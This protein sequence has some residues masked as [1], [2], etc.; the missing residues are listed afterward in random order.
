[1][2]V[3][4]QL[5]LIEKELR[6][7]ATQALD[8]RA[9]IKTARAKITRA[10]DQIGGDRKANLRQIF[11]TVLD[12]WV[13]RSG[14]M[15][16]ARSVGHAVA[17]RYSSEIYILATSVVMVA[18]AYAMGHDAE[19]LQMVKTLYDNLKGAKKSPKPTV[20]TESNKSFSWNL[21][22]TT[23]KH[24]SPD[25]DCGCS[26]EKK[27]VEENASACATGAGSI[28]GAAVPM[29][30]GARSG[31]LR[32]KRVSRLG[33][34]AR[35]LDLRFLPS[36]CVAWLMDQ[37]E[38]QRNAAMEIGVAAYEI[39]NPVALATLLRHDTNVLVL[40]DEGGRAVIH[41]YP[42][43]GVSVNDEMATGHEHI[44]R[45][46]GGIPAD[47]TS[48]DMP[49]SPAMAPQQAVSAPMAP[50]LTQQAPVQEPQAIGV[51]TDPIADAT[52][53][54]TWGDLVALAQSV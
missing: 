51:V 53:G 21:P 8:L 44:E 34:T 50:D 52:D 15:A 38:A 16:L 33:E 10:L 46:L 39:G 4:A 47:M 45:V 20:T 42:D 11:K 31:K 27:P 26:G 6:P 35:N 7:E 9:K 43:G 19:A 36:D 28:G 37:P 13:K 12:T 18:N 14:N 30:F 2:D 1:M 32:K 24:K 54:L 29:L 41:V 3:A 49:T 22:K 25:G 17:S 5:L 23:S 40:R 48:A